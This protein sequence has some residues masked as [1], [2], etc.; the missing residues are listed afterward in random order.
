MCG[1]ARK[2]TQKKKMG[3]EICV[4]FIILLV[5]RRDQLFNLFVIQ[6]RFHLASILKL[7]FIEHEQC[8]KG[9]AWGFEAKK[10]NT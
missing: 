10:I 6:R 2:A 1:G 5:D 3:T 4:I 9:F 8:L 7:L